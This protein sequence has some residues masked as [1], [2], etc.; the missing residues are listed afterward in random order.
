MRLVVVDVDDTLYL[1]RDYVRSG[2][3][4]VGAVI[5]AEEYGD[6]CWELF[7]AGVRGDTFTRAAV[8]I[9][10]EPTDEHVARCV[11]AYRGHAPAISL[12][13]DASALLA[14][15]T[16]VA[17]LGVVTDGP[18][19]SQRAKVLALGLERLVDRV[20][21]TDELGPGRSKP[22]P[23]AFELLQKHAGANGRDCVYIAD[24][25]A[26]D[27]IAPAAL[28]WR[29]VRVRRPDGLHA[30]VES[31]ADVGQVVETLAAVC[32]DAA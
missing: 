32:L 9:G 22:H 26:K 27:F 14:R 21:V 1:E 11:A 25:P 4:A 31:G 13:P 17:Y 12:L 18:A 28:G 19:V 7:L 3:R 29:T 5:G 2:F 30:A 24:N 15:L 6:L 20:V 23:A 10:I 16:G 8:E